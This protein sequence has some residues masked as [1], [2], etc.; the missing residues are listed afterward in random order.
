VH[1]DHGYGN[2][3]RVWTKSE[4]KEAFEDYLMEVKML[5]TE[6]WSPLSVDDVKALNERHFKIFFRELKRFTPKQ[7]IVDE[8]K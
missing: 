4:L 6:D 1:Q 7:R 2:L 5:E 8:E 3:M